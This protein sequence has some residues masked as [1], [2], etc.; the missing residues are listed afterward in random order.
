MY[1]TIKKD[2]WDKNSEHLLKRYE[3]EYENEENQGY[4][5]ETYKDKI[6]TEYDTQGWDDTEDGQPVLSWS[7]DGIYV[8]SKCKISQEI[9]K[10]ILNENPSLIPV[11]IEVITKKFNQVKS[12]LESA[13]AL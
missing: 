12:L 11:A 10:D 7:N 8:S 2:W 6:F 3:D 9:L 4:L 13:K 5:I 1:I